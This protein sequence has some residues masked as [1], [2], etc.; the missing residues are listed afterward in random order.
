V[1]TPLRLLFAIRGIFFLALPFL[2]F[3]E[4]YTLD[5]KGSKHFELSA[6]FVCLKQLS[7]G[8]VLHAF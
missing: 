3:G 8:F 5:K 2:S 4:M 1:S 7:V 6:G